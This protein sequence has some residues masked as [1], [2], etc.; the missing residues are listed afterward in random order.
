MSTVTLSV[1][2]CNAIPK[3]LEIRMTLVGTSIRPIEGCPGPWPWHSETVSDRKIA[4]YWL[5]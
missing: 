3:V 5:L 4:L 2:N 1:G